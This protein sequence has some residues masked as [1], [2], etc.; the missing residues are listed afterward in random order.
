MIKVFNSTFEISL[1]ILLILKCVR[2]ELSIDKMLSF[3]YLATY[4]KEFKI[5][6]YN[7]HG[8]NNYSF[9]ELTAKRDI[10]N[11]AIKELVLKEYVIP[12]YSKKGFLYKIS[13]I[14]MTFCDFLNDIYAKEYLSNVSN[15][16]EIF[17]NYSDFQLTNFIS[18][19]AIS[20][21]GGND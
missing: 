11:K 17:E 7:L 10:M 2:N 18:Q 3:D 20:M 5:S 21:F 16:I 12:C 13:D 4:G 6:Q 9:C 15:V 1:R 14:G 19:H 8:E